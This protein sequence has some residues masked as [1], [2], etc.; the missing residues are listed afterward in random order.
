MG[1]TAHIQNIILNYAFK[2][3]GGTAP[4]TWYVGLCTDDPLITTEN[5]LAFDDYVRIAVTFTSALAGVTQNNADLTFTSAA[6]G[7]WGSLT[8]VGVFDALT[9]GNLLVSIPLDAAFDVS[10]GDPVVIPAGTLSIA[11]G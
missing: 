2:A 4:S 11:L 6:E 5:E 8:Y 3:V 7:S 1:T 9:D 10:S